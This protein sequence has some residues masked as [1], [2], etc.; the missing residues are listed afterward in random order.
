[1]RLKDARENQYYYSGK[2]GD[3]GRQLALGGIAAVWILHGQPGSLQF[4][5]VLL[6]ALVGFLLA[7]GL[8][9]L[10]YW[11]SASIWAAFARLKELEFQELG[12]DQDN[13]KDLRGDFTVSRKINWPALFFFHGK[14][15]ALIFG[16]CR[17]GWFMWQKISMPPM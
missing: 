15:L 12:V 9:F 16:A 1:M 7:L 13:E 11:I 8:D 4:P 5:V 10:Q 6:E 14:A 3:V 17:L 2:A